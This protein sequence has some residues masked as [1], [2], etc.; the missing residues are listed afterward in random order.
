MGLLNAA[1]ARLPLADAIVINYLHPVFTVLFQGGAFSAGARAVSGWEEGGKQD[2][3]PG[4]P[5]M[6]LG[7]ALCLAGVAMIA[8]GGR[9]RALGE[10]RSTAGALAALFAAI[11]W[12][13][14]SNLGRFVRAKPGRR[15]SDSADLQTFAAMTFG[16]LMLGAVLG[17][18]GHLRGPS[19]YSTSLFLGPLG[20]ARV[21]AWYV[22]GTMG[23]VLYCGG[24]TV[25]LLAL[26]VGREAGE[27]HKLPALTY[28][29]PVLSVALGWLLLH[30]SFGPA[31]WQGAALIAAGNLVILLGRDAP[32]PDRAGAENPHTDH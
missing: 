12:G 20:P 3:R 11:A 8:T 19:G 27:P 5:R 2:R 6:A 30:E 17:L 23:A 31:F 32:R 14:Y 26:A 24:F 4:W 18:G 1:L 22:I 25:W 15:T 7:L 10:L 16:L 13:V 28:L 21:S 29:T 9:L